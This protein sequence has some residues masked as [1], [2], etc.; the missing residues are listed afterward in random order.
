MTADPKTS[1]LRLKIGGGTRHRIVCAALGALALERGWRVDDFTAY[2]PQ[3]GQVLPDLVI[4]KSEK[5]HQGARIVRKDYRYRIE[6][7]DSHDPIPDG[8]PGFGFNGVVKVLVSDWER[9]CSDKSLENLPHPPCYDG[10]LWLLE[11]S[12]P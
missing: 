2:R 8:N 4:S 10:L 1:T 3:E 11:R 7:I 9:H 6:V 5:V 12:L